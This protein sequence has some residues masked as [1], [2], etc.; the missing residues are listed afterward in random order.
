MNCAIRRLHTQ[1]NY[2]TNTRHL[3]LF[4]YTVSMAKEFQLKGITSL[5]SLK[6]GDKQ[7]YEVEGL[8]GA[9]VLLVN[10]GGKINALSPKCTHY[11]APVSLNSNLSGQ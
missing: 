1:F 9:K 5:D 4:H 10:A 6:P 11:G 2:F 3:R 8:E 7:D